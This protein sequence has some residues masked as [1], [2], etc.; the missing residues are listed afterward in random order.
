MILPYAV[1]GYGGYGGS[2]DRGDG[3]YGWEDSASGTEMIAEGIFDKPE[4]E[5]TELFNRYTWNKKR[6]VEPPLDEVSLQQVMLPEYDATF[7]ATL[8]SNYWIE[9]DYNYDTYF[10]L[11]DQENEIDVFIVGLHPGGHESCTWA[12]RDSYLGGLETLYDI[13]SYVGGDDHPGPGMSRSDYYFGGYDEYNDPGYIA[14][15]Y[16]GIDLSEQTGRPLDDIYRDGQLCWLPIA[17]VFGDYYDYFGNY[18]DSCDWNEFDLD[19]R[20]IIFRDY[21]M[22]ADWDPSLNEGD[23]G[24]GGLHREETPQSY[25]VTTGTDDMGVSQAT[26]DEAAA[27]VTADPSLLE[28]ID[29]YYEKL[30]ESEYWIDDNGD[31]HRGF[32]DI[33]QHGSFKPGN[34]DKGGYWWNDGDP[35]TDFYEYEFWSD[36]DFESYEFGLQTVGAGYGGYGGY[37][38]D[39]R[40]FTNEKTLE[41]RINS[42]GYLAYLV[43]VDE[44]VVNRKILELQN[45]RDV[46]DSIR[47]ARSVAAI[48]ERDAWYAQNADAMSGRVTRDHE[49]N[50]VRAQQY[51]LRNDTSVQLI[52]ASKRGSEISSMV[53]TTNFRN[54][55]E[56]NLT[57]LPWNDWLG[58][59]EEGDRRFV[60]TSFPEEGHP[61]LLSMDVKFA[62]H[63]NESLQETRSFDVREPGEGE[64]FWFNEILGDTLTI[65]DVSSFTYT[66]G[67]PGA[68]EYSIDTFSNGFSYEF[69]AVGEDTPTIDVNFYVAQD[70]DDGLGTGEAVPYALAGESQID[71]IWDALRVNLAPGSPYVEAA[72]L[73]IEIDN[74]NMTEYFSQAIDV[75]YIPMSRMLWKGMVEEGD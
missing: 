12:D 56:G 62:N 51:V 13:H 66:G 73:E 1:C 42:S 21:R 55:Y 65:N 43:Q 61:D 53:F 44:D 64:N 27:Y 33:V 14:N 31:V 58:T 46:D 15:S 20:F 60:F 29:D 6:T 45:V 63:V 28:D 36:S 26:R 47:D 8:R 70:G 48:R 50:W 72:N 59:V 75:I 52:N 23:G 7:S 74:G 17:E 10:L 18:D 68:N 67:T 54:S 40:C 3:G 34:F 37:N 38:Q 30:P 41:E 2:L 24:Y 9:F 22:V 5:E 11:H 16:F 49:G 4:V 35:E 32:G 57:E 71:D 19:E 25:T 39:L 69:E